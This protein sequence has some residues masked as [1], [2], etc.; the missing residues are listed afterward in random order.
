MLYLALHQPIQGN[1]DCHSKRN[2]S[3][4][5]PY[6]ENSL[7]S[8]HISPFHYMLTVP[9][10]FW[11]K[12]NSLKKTCK[13]AQGELTHTLQILSTT[14]CWSPGWHSHCLKLIQTLGVQALIQ[15]E[16][17]TLLH[18]LIQASPLQR[19]ES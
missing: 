14:Y 9:R 1:L 2:F 10:C 16:H 6:T 11:H 7:K 12:P 15:T 8:H 4:K 5:M 18:L 3:F 17:L 19:Q 13:N